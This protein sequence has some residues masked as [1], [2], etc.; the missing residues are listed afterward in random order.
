MNKQQVLK[1]AIGFLYTTFGII[2]FFQVSPLLSSFLQ[3]GLMYYLYLSRKYSNNNKN[4]YLMFLIVIAIIGLNNL[5]NFTKEYTETKSCLRVNE[6]Y[7]GTS[8]YKECINSLKLS[9]YLV[10]LVQ[11]RY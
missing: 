2:L 7:P 3:I 11:V 5:A 8:N 10:S 6:S 1:L 4:L 9:D